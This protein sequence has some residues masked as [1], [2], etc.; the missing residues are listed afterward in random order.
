MSKWTIWNCFAVALLW[1][2]VGSLGMVIHSARL[3][4]SLNVSTRPP[5]APTIHKTNGQREFGHPL[6]PGGIHT[7]AELD[8]HRHLY[9]GFPGWI[10][11]T[12]TKV[13]GFAY[14]SYIKNGVLYWTKHPRFIKA[15]EP[16]IVSDGLVIL[17]NCGNMVR[18]DA[19]APVE[20]LSTEPD[21]LYPPEDAPSYIGGPQTP[22]T[23]TSWGWDTGIYVY[24]NTFSADAVGDNASTTFSVP[25]SYWTTGPN[26]VQPV[27][28]PSSG[29]MVSMGLL[30]ILVLTGHPSFRKSKK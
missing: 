3:V 17:Q 26:I 14:V 18:Y 24:N 20:T 21:D 1:G 27:A 25:P 7:Y 13:G 11:F 10:T 15:G 19:P 5:A 16:V 12:T 9:G 28:E 8:Q 23:G 6:V 4:E 2:A 30:A 22:L 29:W